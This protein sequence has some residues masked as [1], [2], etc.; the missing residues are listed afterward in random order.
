M[1]RAFVALE[2]S[3]EIKSRLGEAQNILKKCN[4]RL[5]LVEP[6]N[7]HITVKFLGDVEDKKIQDIATVLKSIVCKP[8]LVNVEKVTV[9][10]P[11]RPFTIWCAINDAGS[12]GQLYQQ[13]ERDLLPLGFTPESRRFNPHATIARIKRYEPSLMETIKSL[14][15]RTYGSCMVTGLKL[16]KSTLTPQGPIYEDLLEVIW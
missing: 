7:I 10:N 2:L 15:S 4:A 1:V 8:F 16:K 5:T 13:I 12:N 11:R 3:D 14:E 9:N 6:K